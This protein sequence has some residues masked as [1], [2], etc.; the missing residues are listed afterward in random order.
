MTAVE[1]CPICDIAGC[2]HI[3]ERKAKMTHPTD[4]EMDARNRKASQFMEELHKQVCE[5]QGDHPDECDTAYSLASYALA[6]LTA[7]RAQRA[8]AWAAVKLTAEI[9]E[10]AFARADRAEAALAAQIEADAGL[11]DAEAKY[12]Q[13]IAVAQMSKGIPWQSSEWA[14][15]KLTDAAEEIRNQPHDRSAL[16]RHDADTRA[17]A[18]RE[19]ADELKGQG[20]NTAVRQILAMI[21]GGKP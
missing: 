10:K 11:I 13:E 21:E 3:R 4:E 17:K 18:L 16:D 8:E 7:L 14:F 12:Q 15:R 20:Y 6:A 1:V 5:E 19:A 2:R 9:S